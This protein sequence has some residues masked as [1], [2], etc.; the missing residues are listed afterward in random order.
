MYRIHEKYINSQSIIKINNER[1]KELKEQNQ[2]VIREII[3]NYGTYWE[4]QILHVIY[5][6]KEV[7]PETILIVG[8][9]IGLNG[10]NEFDIIYSYKECDI[11][12]ICGK[13]AKVY[14]ISEFTL[15]NSCIVEVLYENIKPI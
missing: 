15:N 5:D 7:N 9:K 10:Q 6:N 2:K 12:G 11:S 13:R 3:D 8:Q 14:E 4:G 1:I